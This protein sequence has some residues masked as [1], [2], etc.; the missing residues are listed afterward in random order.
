MWINIYELQQNL[1]YLIKVLRKIIKYSM[2]LE[3]YIQEL[4]DTIKYASYLHIYIYIIP[5]V[6]F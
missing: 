2:I 1:N 4:Q 3:I 6:D 5:L